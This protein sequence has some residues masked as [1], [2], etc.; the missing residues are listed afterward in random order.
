MVTLQY[1]ETGF[2]N[3]GM[4]SQW[5]LAMFF[6]SLMVNNMGSCCWAGCFLCQVKLQETWYY[7]TSFHFQSQLV[8]SFLPHR[9]SIL[10]PLHAHHGYL[11]RS[12]VSSSCCD[13]RASHFPPALDVSAVTAGRGGQ[14]LREWESWCTCLERLHCVYISGG[15][16]EQGSGLCWSSVMAHLLVKT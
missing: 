14:V 13:Q 16:S 2:Y 3:S 6:F 7:T 10:S 11:T 15:V 4:L 5:E 1:S 8:H 12:S 9:S